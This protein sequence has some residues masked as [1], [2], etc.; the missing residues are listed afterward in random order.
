MRQRAVRCGHALYLAKHQHTS[1]TRETQVRANPC[2]GGTP[3]FHRLMRRLLTVLTSL[4]ACASPYDTQLPDWSAHQRKGTRLGDLFDVG[5]IP[6]FSSFRANCFPRR[7]SD[8]LN[9]SPITLSG[10]VRFGISLTHQIFSA[11]VNAVH[12]A[13]N[14]NIDPCPS[15][16]IKTTTRRGY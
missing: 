5:G 2:G 6:S 10:R 13:M 9:S 16:G 7:L 3:T 4:R 15:Q 14:A 11:A 1:K 8:E 12:M